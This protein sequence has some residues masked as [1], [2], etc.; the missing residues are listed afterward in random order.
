MFFN[1]VYRRF[2]KRIDILKKQKSNLFY[3]C[4][5]IPSLLLFVVFFMIPVI[6][7]LVLSFTDSFGLKTSYHFIGLENY[8]EALTDPSFMQTI[9]V[10]L[11]FTTIAVV[12]GNIVSI[13]LALLLDSSMKFR[14]LLRSVFFI[15]NIM[16]LLVV[17]YVWSFVYTKTVPDL[18]QA[19]GMKSVAI[20]GNMNLVVPALALAAIWNAAGY[21]MVIYL[22]ALQGVSEDLLEA[23]RIDGAGPATLLFRIKLPLISPTIITC[24][25][26]SIAAHIKVF[27]LPYAM[28]SGGPAGASTTLVLKIY[29]TAFNA[30]RTGYATAQSTIMFIIIASVTL[31]LNGLMKRREERIS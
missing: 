19:M 23:A 16:S 8:R 24:L 18:L 1:I 12:L 26:L 30:N 5:L 28:T 11:E 4:I 21:Y 29:N 27:E 20:L 3:V 6:Q 25:I 13:G 31:I 15:P 17:G 10:S 14:S 9:W 7:S 2:E 22:A